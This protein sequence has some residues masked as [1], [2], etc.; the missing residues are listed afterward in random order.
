M[1]FLLIPQDRLLRT[2][3][4]I[5]PDTLVALQA[6]T[7]DGNVVCLDLQSGSPFDPP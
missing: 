7:L 3:F 4:L 2:A 5:V 6:G 1:R